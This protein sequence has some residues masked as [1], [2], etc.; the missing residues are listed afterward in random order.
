MLGPYVEHTLPF[1]PSRQETEQQ[2]P[3]PETPGEASPI[4]GM[5]I[6]I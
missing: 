6:V 5:N 2:G 3:G 1:K 4:K